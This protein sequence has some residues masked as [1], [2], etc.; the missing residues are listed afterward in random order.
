MALRKVGE[1]EKYGGIR[2]ETKKRTILA[3]KI[4]Q[5]RQETIERNQAKQKNLEIERE[6]IEE[7]KSQ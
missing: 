4:R 7:K 3:N 5:A 6:F 1:I 2:E